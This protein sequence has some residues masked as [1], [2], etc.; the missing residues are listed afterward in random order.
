MRRALVFLRIVDDHDGNISLSNIV[1]IVV[2]VKIV[3]IPHPN[4]FDLGSLLAVVLNYNTKKW[5]APDPTEIGNGRSV[6]GSVG[7]GGGLVG[8]LVSAGERLSTTGRAPGA[9]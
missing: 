9:I 8:V 3:L 7:P 5:L 2:M 1:F 4:M 6:S